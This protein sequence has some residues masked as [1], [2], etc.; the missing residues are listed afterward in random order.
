MTSVDEDAYTKPFM[1]TKSMHRNVYPSICPAN[2]SVEDKVVVITGAAGGIGYG[3]A[4][5][6]NAGKAKG[7]VLLGRSAESLEKVAKDIVAPTRPMII[8]TDVLSLAACE[9]A[10]SKAIAEF[11]RVDALINAAGAMEMGPGPAANPSKIAKEV[12]VHGTY[13]MLHAFI[14][15]TGGKGTVVNLVSVGASFLAPGLSGYSSSKLA[16]IKLGECLD[17]E[18]PG[19]RSFSVHPGMVEAENGRGIV[20][21]AFT[22]FAKDKAAL[23]GGLTTYLVQPKADFLR[24]TY[25]H[26]NWD[27]D[28]LNEHKDEIAEKKLNK[29]AFLRAEL[30]PDGYPWES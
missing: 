13:N 28:E 11:G 24:G 30:R 15:A 27:V 12:N 7:V 5:S 26:A 14:N 23:F 29:L 9:E 19:I 1:L 25:L 3:T 18:H 17:L 20:V 16:V 8:P 4:R 6:W 2:N 10:F 21:D 22:P